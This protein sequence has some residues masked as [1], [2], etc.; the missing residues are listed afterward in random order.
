MKTMLGYDIVTREDLAQNRAIAWENEHTTRLREM[1]GVPVV[2][3]GWDGDAE[4]W[5][6]AQKLT[7]AISEDGMVDPTGLCFEDYYRPIQRWEE[8]SLDSSDPDNGK[9]LPLE[10]GRLANHIQKML[11]VGNRWKENRERRTLEATW[12][13]QAL[14]RKYETMARAARPAARKFLDSLCGYMG[15]ETGGGARKHFYKGALDLNW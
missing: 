10:Y 9:P 12:E 3:I 13:Q 5:I 2:A 15:K 1:S 6:I 4:R 8:S 14:D 11:Y 7:V